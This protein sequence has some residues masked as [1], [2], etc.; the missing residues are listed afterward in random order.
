MRNLSP[1]AAAVNGQVL[2]YTSLFGLGMPQSLLSAIAVSL[3]PGQSNTL[4]FP[5]T[6]A[7]LNGTDQR[8]GTYVRIV[9][10]SDRHLI[11]N[12]GAQLLA[13]AYCSA[14]GRSF[15]V[16]FPV[17]NPLSTSQ[18]ITLSML[19]NVLNAVVQPA[20]RVFNPLEQIIATLNLQVPG[21]LHGTAGTPI[22]QDATVAA[23]GADGNLIGGLTYVVW[24]DN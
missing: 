24:I 17:M 6:Q 19:P 3:A 2:L 11:N 12:R 18:Q 1:T 20:T 16:T 14:V 22:R 23:Y 4:L 9:H 15:S 7:I 13:D 8:I 10:P 5:L 21:S